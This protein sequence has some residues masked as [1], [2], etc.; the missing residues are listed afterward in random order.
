M[1]GFIGQLFA[2]R[3]RPRVSTARASAERAGAAAEPIV[4]AGANGTRA[5]SK[6]EAAS[7]QLCA[8]IRMFFDDQDAIA[9]H[10]LA[11]AAGEIFE[12]L[13]KKERLVPSIRFVERTK[14]K[15]ID[16]RHSLGRARN[17]FKHADTDA[18][19]VLEFS[20]AMNDLVVLLASLDAAQVLKDG[21]PVEIDAYI[22]WYFTI[23]LSEAEADGEAGCWQRQD[24][25]GDRKVYQAMQGIRSRSRREQ[26]R[27][28]GR[29]LAALDEA[30]KAS[31]PP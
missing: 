7:R 11:C 12:K 8:A 28:A 25:L 10:T 2:L 22:S 9:V 1:A 21:R 20:D 5:I 15:G 14:P 23:Y 4:V 6:T 3:R 26:K 18:D 27:F 19:A 31:D 30:A 16:A 13:S 24:Q 29:L 17:F